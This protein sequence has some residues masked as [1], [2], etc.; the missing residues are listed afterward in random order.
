MPVDA[1]AR[2]YALQVK[3]QKER[4]VAAILDHKGY[5]AYLPLY[6]TATAKT[7]RAGNEERPLF[8]GYVFCRA[9]LSNRF[10]P[11]ITT[12]GVIRFVGWAARPAP[13]DHEEMDWLMRVVDSPHNCEPFSAPRI[14]ER[15]TIT[16]GPLRG[17][18]GCLCAAKGE[19]R[20]VIEITIVNRCIGIEIDDCTIARSC[21]AGAAGSL[22]ALAQ[23]GCLLGHTRASGEAQF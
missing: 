13:I 4:S 2:W 1:G 11:V 7:G 23:N 6:R 21:G 15:V 9:D 5:E 16:S 18:E 3:A 17:L 14:G 12:P 10:A 22:E 8:P 19:N 20:L